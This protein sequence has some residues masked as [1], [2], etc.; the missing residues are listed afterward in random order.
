MD[1]RNPFETIAK[2]IL[3]ILNQIESNWVLQLIGWKQLKTI[4]LKK[5][6]ENNS[7]VATITRLSC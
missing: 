3:Y 4:T 5:C 1:Q 7:H 2:T 6:T